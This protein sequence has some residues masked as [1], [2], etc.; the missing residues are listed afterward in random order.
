MR[1]CA[2]SEDIW[3]E[4]NGYLVWDVEAIAGVVPEREAE[5][6]GGTHESRKGVAVEDGLSGADGPPGDVQADVALEA[7]G[8]ERDLRGASTVCNYALLVCRRASRR[9][10]MS[11]PGA[12][13]EDAIEAG[14]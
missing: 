10:S 8:V 7:N 5:L 14:A 13:S 4:G 1:W 6:R 12:P 3:Q 9:S 2:T 11:K